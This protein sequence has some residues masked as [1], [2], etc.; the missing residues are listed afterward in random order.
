MWLLWCFEWFSECF[1]GLLGVVVVF[2]V[3]ARVLSCFQ[4]VFGVF[5]VVAMVF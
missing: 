2:C 5:W 3:V 1:W 4:N